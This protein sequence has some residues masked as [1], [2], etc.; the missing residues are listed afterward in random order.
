MICAIVAAPSPAASPATSSPV[1]AFGFVNN[2]MPQPSQLP[3]QEGRLAAARRS[4]DRAHRLTKLGQARLEAI[5]YLSPGLTAASG[6]K[7]ER[8]ALMDEGERPQGL[9]RFRVIKPWRD[10][11]NAVPDAPRKVA[12]GNSEVTQ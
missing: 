2:L 8:P 6:S 9:V 3:A 5:S 12:G 10:L 7:S 11:I 4:R 1:W